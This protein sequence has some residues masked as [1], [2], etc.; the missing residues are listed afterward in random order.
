VTL[1]TECRATR[2][3]L[4][5]LMGRKPG[6]V[7]DRETSDDFYR[8]GRGQLVIKAM[9]KQMINPVNWVR[10]P[11]TFLATTQA[12][13]S[14]APIWQWPRLAFAIIRVGPAA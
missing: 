6:L 14:N 11:A 2:L 8:M 10:L 13:D 4:I 5:T 9:M 7:R 1:P 3:A 12:V